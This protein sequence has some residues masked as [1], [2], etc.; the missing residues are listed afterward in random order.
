MSIRVAVIGDI[1]G[2]REELAREL[3]RL[4]ADDNGR[5]PDDL[6][7]VQVGDLIHRGPDSDGV[8]RLVDRY[9][10]KQPERW[11]QLIGNHEA[12]YLRPP[13]FDWNERLSFG[14]RRTVRRWWRDGIAHAAV[15]VHTTDEEFL[16]THAGVTEP[17]WRHQLDSA[18]SA[19]ESAAR[20]NA[21]ARDEDTAL[22]DGGCILGGGPPN[23]R[24]GPIWADRELELL[25]GWRD[26][27]MPFSQVHGHSGSHGDC[28]DERTFYDAR[29]RHE[30]TLLEGGRIIGIDPGHR[31][32]PQ[33]NWRSLV[34]T[35]TE[36]PRIA[37]EHR[38]TA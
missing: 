10:R 12:H 22:F 7:V 3:R 27:P 33:R 20:I 11:I 16:I 30:V 37:Y 2:H 25:P 34:L 36:P 13:V 35:A 19:A 17:F 29:Q 38:A 14:S 32:D 24:V 28:A 31:A 6:V 4:G 9:L 1:G 23:P 8:V 26:R 21:T 15:A 18:V 5:L